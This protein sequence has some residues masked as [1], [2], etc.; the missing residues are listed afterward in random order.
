M[1]RARFGITRGVSMQQ[2]QAGLSAYALLLCV[3]L[4]ATFWIAAA[5]VAIR[6]LR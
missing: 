4:G 5:T 1:L 6:L 2:R 3:V